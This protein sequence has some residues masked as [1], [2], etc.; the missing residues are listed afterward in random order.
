MKI[1]AIYGTNHVGSTVEL[2]RALISRLPHTQDELSEFFLPRDFGH[3]CNGCCACFEAAA[4]LCVQAGDQLQPILQAIDA[5]DVIIL[6][7]PVYVYHVTGAMKSFLDHL[8]CRWLI[9]RPNGSMTGKTAVLLTTA[10]GSGTKQTLGDLKDSMNW[11]GVGHVYAYGRRVQALHPQQVKPK[12]KSAI[13]QDM[14]KLAR[15][16]LSARRSK[17]RIGVR[18]RYWLSKRM[19]GGL[20][21]QDHAYWQE[22][23]WLKGKLPWK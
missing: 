3:V 19:G 15:R 7:S 21:P 13:E 2:A 8:G 1:T 10:A 4:P 14:G 20:T 22:Q 6:A 16:I 12:I 9:H 23:G 5:A 11:W 17:P 18:A